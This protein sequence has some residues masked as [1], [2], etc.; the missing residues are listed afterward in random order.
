[1]RRRGVTVLEIVVVTT[2]LLVIAAI[3]FPV[4]T[5]SKE[6]AKETVCVSNIR[7]TL[8]ALEL[9]ANDHDGNYPWVAFPSD[10]AI[11]KYMGGTELRCFIRLGDQQERGEYVLSAARHPDA[12]FYGEPDPN[13]PTKYDDCRSRRS[14]DFPFVIDSNHVRKLQHATAGRSALFVGRANGSV[15]TVVDPLQ[16]LTGSPQPLPCSPSLFFLNL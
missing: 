1:M 6:R 16:K 14:G 10:P 9:Y 12:S 11:K 8:S 3:L 15:S 2:I 5:R 7:Q 13:Y 4:F